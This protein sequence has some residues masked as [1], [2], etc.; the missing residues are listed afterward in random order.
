MFLRG[1][2]LVRGTLLMPFQG[3]GFVPSLFRGSITPPL[4][5]V[6]DRLDGHGAGPLPHAA[7]TESSSRSSERLPAVL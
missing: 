6:P 1:I 5:R 7:F 2:L 4:G 3:R